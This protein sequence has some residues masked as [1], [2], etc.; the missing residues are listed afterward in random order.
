MEGE[1]LLVLSLVK[2]PVR[3]AGDWLAT[4]AAAWAVAAAPVFLFVPLGRSC[5]GAGPSTCVNPTIAAVS[6]LAAT[7]AFLV[8]ALVVGILPFVLRRR[9]GWLR[10]WA[11][12]PLLVVLGTFG[13]DV[14]IL[15]AAVLAL[16]ASFLPA[17]TAGGAAWR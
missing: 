10:A 11:L 12:L 9:R 17:P 4:A 8:M 6:P 14:W 3:G 5:A 1:S 7:L 2:A 15:P 13:A 16:I